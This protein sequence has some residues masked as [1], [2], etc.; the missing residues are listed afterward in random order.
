MN[1]MLCFLMLINS[2]KFHRLFLIPEGSH[3]PVFIEDTN[4]NGLGELIF[5]N[6][7]DN[8]VIWEYRPPDR[9]KRVY[10]KSFPRPDSDFSI[11][12]VGDGDRDGLLEILGR[13]SLKKNGDEIRGTAILESRD[14][15]SFPISMVWFDTS[16]NADEYT[17]DLDN[18]G[19]I[20]LW[21]W[22]QIWENDGDN[23]Y[24]KVFEM[25]SPGHNVFGDFDKDGRK[26]WW[27]GYDSLVVWECKGD[28]RYEKVWK[29][30]LVGGEEMWKGNDTDGDGKPE[31]FMKGYSP[32]VH[33]KRAVYMYETV[34][35]NAFEFK[36]IDTIQTLL[37][38][39]YY[40]S[41]TCG[42]V[43]GDGREEVIISLGTEVVIYKAID[44]DRYKKVWEWRN[45]MGPLFHDE[46]YISCYDF[47]KDGC[48]EIVITGGDETSIFKIDK[49][50][51][52]EKSSETSPLRLSISPNPFRRRVSI[53]WQGIDKKPISIEIYNSMGTLVKRFL[54]IEGLKHRIEWRGDDDR[55]NSVPPSVYFC[56][57]KQGN[58]KLTRKIVLMGK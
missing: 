27:S 53:G 7:Q 58:N 50:S 21:S 22:T 6:W 12:D 15:L 10:A 32:D 1:W 13:L 19:K 56:R 26:E 3:K 25:L 16:C 18:D 36:T 29:G 5:Q 46:A 33:P 45:D 4:H 20:E 24:L 40:E 57:L 2:Y 49:T 23:R 37:G 44:N 9:F 52:E 38:E 8:L 30:P 43:D 28:N 41:S 35:N 54:K 42:D 48:D 51:I 31:V 47:D 11:L 55:G 34:G 14:S 39:S 17:D